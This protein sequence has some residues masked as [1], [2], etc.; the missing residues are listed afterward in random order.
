VDAGGTTHNATVS[1]KTVSF[2]G[3][4]GNWTLYIIVSS[5][6]YE[7]TVAIS[8][9]YNR[10]LPNLLRKDAVGKFIEVGYQYYADNIKNF[11]DVVTAF[12][13]DEPTLPEAIITGSIPQAKVSWSDD[14]E[15]RFYDMHGYSLKTHYHSLFEGNTPQG[16]G[17]CAST[18]AKPQPRCLP[19]T[20][21][22]RLRNGAKRMA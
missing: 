16:Y 14:V 12:F 20:I 18:T 15:A 19:R 2:A 10:K 7:G 13:T 21:P 11:S 22:D 8:G 3:V 5:R 9:G 17:W 6:M 4:N 1:G